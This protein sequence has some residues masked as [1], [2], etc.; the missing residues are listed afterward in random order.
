MHDPATVPLSPALSPAEQQRLLEAIQRERQQL[1]DERRRFRQE[2]ADLRNYWRRRLR[3]EWQRLEQEAVQV[4]RERQK[5]KEERQQAT[6]QDELQRRQLEAE[7]HELRNQQRSWRE[8][9][10]RRESDLAARE[11]ALGQT[12]Q[13]LE[14]ARASWDDSL[15]ELQRIQQRKQAELCG[16]ESRIAH[17]RTVLAR[18]QTDRARVDEQLTPTVVALPRSLALS[19]PDQAAADRLLAILTDLKDE[20][21]R[22][23]RFHEGLLQLREAWQQEWDRAE[24]ALADREADLEEREQ[25]L[26]E[27]SQMLRDWMLQLHRQ[28]DE[29]QHRSQQVLSTEAR[30]LRQRSELHCER[31]RLLALVR[32]RAMAARARL[33]LGFELR[34]KAVDLSLEYAAR[35]Q[36]LAD[37]EL[38]QRR[39][40]LEC[41]QQLERRQSWLDERERELQ[42]KELALFHAEQQLLARD[43]DPVEA[44]AE[45]ER[46]YQ[47]LLRQAQ[48][49]LR[50]LEQREAELVALH[51]EL[52]AFRHRLLAEEQVLCRE[53]TQLEELRL[54]HER[55]RA[56]WESSRLRWRQELTTLRLENRRLQEHVGELRDQLERLALVLLETPPPQPGLKLALA[57]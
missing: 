27:R 48:R 9:Q 15:H 12:R 54:T 16:L 53:R 29:N 2:Q 3:S 10:I 31:G 14:A 19:P 20:E 7:W 28:R 51:E 34:E 56:L 26:R 47:H 44:A 32:A 6:T 4:Q 1:A 13:H 5:L 38:Q 40:A 43:P 11:Q 46:R 25:A 57:A 49:P 33:R 45:L 24:A 55:R 21:A 22:L 23:A 35:Q 8:E 41:Q 30:L 36:Q 42:A 39:D 17:L 52:E 50:R 37:R 18:L